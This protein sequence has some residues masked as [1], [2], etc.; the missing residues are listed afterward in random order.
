[1][2]KK[3]ALLLAAVLAA[4]AMTACGNGAADSAAPAEET[5]TEEAA[6]EEAAA[7]EPAAEDAVSYVFLDETL[8]VESYA[9][10]FR[11]GDTE[12]AETVSGAVQALVLDGTYD[13]IGKKYPEIYDYLCLKAEDIDESTLPERGSG[14]PGF[15][16]LSSG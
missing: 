3:I 8:G 15:I 1:M 5:V 7:E 13:E 14:D 12:L 2:K 10:G 9:I 6:T 4:T 11:L 16:F